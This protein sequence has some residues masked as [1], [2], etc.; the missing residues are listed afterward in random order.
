MSEPAY[1]LVELPCGC[2]DIHYADGRVDR[3]HDHVECDG[4]PV[5]EAGS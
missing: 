1:T 4:R 2:Q 3:E 5:P